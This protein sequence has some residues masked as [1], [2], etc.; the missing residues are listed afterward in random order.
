[1]R[2]SNVPIITFL[3][4]IQLF[5]G[6]AAIIVGGIAFQ[7]RRSSLW[8]AVPS[9]FSSVRLRLV[10][11]AVAA[12][13]PY[14][15]SQDRLRSASSRRL[16][17]QI[18]TFSSS[19]PAMRAPAKEKAEDEAATKMWEARGLPIRITVTPDRFS[20]IP[21][22]LRIQGPFTA[23]IHPEGTD[24]ESDSILGGY[25]EELLAKRISE[26][27][28]G[29]AENVDSQRLFV[30][31]CA[32]M[33]FLSLHALALGHRVV[34]VEPFDVDNELLRASVVENSGFPHRFRLIKAV[35]VENVTAGQDLCMVTPSMAD[36]GRARL[37]PLK[38]PVTM[39]ERDVGRCSGRWTRNDTPNT[40]N[41][42]R[43]DIW[44][45]HGEPYE[46]QLSQLVSGVR[47]DD[48][49][50]PGQDLIHALNADCEGTE[51]IALRGA[52]ALIQHHHP[53]AIFFE[54]NK[55]LTEF[56]GVDGN[57]LLRD[58]VTRGYRLFATGG[59][60]DLTPVAMGPR[61][62]AVMDGDY[63]LRLMTGEERCKSSMKQSS[64]G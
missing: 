19:S 34:A 11:D 24:F 44:E 25:W 3:H 28:G 55:N 26:V 64:L 8:D 29:P 42:K 10:D 21:D 41:P 14:M 33:G 1:M 58:T 2:H 31:V 27:L 18:E 17:L 16:T 36:Q 7:L 22:H 35:A 37:I 56:T 9:K 51:T 61:D 60:E 45:E 20:C 62:P 57:A 12:A 47:L 39:E 32:R 30:D 23:Y 5:A 46:A 40:L 50:V 15:T 13:H 43:F 53:C 54:F 48:V 6:A 38:K 4:L 52:A 59:T 49:L 63:E